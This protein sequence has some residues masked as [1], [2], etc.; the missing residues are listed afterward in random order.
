MITPLALLVMASAV[1]TAV[2]PSFH[3]PFIISGNDSSPGGSPV[4][5]FNWNEDGMND[6]IVDWS[7]PT[8]RPVSTA[9][10]L[11]A[12]LTWNPSQSPA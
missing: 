9:I 12:G 3:S 2:L 1:C 8:A 11:R 4:D 7:V 5:Y 6:A 10:A